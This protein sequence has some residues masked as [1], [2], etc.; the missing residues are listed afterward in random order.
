MVVVGTQ[1]AASVETA[2]EQREQRSMFGCSKFRRMVSKVALVLLLLAIYPAYL[3]SKGYQIARYADENG[4]ALNMRIRLDGFGYS[5]KAN[6][7]ALR[8]KIAF[9][10]AVYAQLQH[11]AFFRQEGVDKGV[12]AFFFAFGVNLS[13]WLRGQ[14]TPEVFISDYDKRMEP[15]EERKMQAEKIRIKNQRQKSRAAAGGK[16]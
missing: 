10:H 8:K 15:A 6:E 9:N 4:V 13:H 11:H 5:L 16:R 1:S 12:S 3:I 7:R 14:A 2:S